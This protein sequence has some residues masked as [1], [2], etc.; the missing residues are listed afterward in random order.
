[1]IT[2]TIKLLFTNETQGQSNV[3]TH[4]PYSALLSQ[5]IKI[6]LSHWLAT[7]LTILTYEPTACTRISIATVLAKYYR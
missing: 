5:D 4:L 2:T 7:R 1:M 3:D 6:L